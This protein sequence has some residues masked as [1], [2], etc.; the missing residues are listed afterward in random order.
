MESHFWLDLV[1]EVI[2]DRLIGTPYLGE[3]IRN[4]LLSILAKMSI[5]D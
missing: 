2:G 1:Q 3:E 5:K 4:L